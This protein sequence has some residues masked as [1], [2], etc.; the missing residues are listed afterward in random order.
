LKNIHTQQYK[1]ILATLLSTLKK[2]V[3]T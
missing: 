1:Y 3:K 2:V